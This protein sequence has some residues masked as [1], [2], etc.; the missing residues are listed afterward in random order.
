ML[1][2]IKLFFLG[3][4]LLIS[5]SGEV[6]GSNAIRAIKTTLVGVGVATVGSWGYFSISRFYRN[7]QVAALTKK[8]NDL[9]VAIALKYAKQ[10]AI[11]KYYHKNKC[12]MVEMDLKLEESIL[13]DYSY[14]HGLCEARRELDLLISKISSQNDET[15][16][17]L[18]LLSKLC[19]AKKNLDWQARW[20]LR[21]FSSNKLKV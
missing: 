14:W 17:L 19:K 10:I 2:N 1:K 8:A 15:S 9:L 20:F 11:I 13:L 16:Q 21:R 7:R 5:G 6:K 18:D 3:L 4:I 12:D